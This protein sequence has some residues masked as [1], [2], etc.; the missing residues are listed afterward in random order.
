LIKLKRV[1]EEADKNDGLRILVD[2]LWPRGLSK[3]KARIDL[4]LKD[5]A[6]SNELRKWFAHQ[7]EKW[8]GFKRRYF[9][10]LDDSESELT[11]LIQKKAEEDVVTLL[12]AAKNE[13]YNN[14]VALKEYL[15]KRELH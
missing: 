6:P 12:Y 11:E 10:E 14:A 2:R 9:K 7:P 3:E 5:L 4:W 15:K 8:A 13:E 1:Y